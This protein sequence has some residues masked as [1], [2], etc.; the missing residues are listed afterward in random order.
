MH[1][2]YKALIED[3]GS[4]YYIILNNFYTAISDAID[5]AGIATTVA[6]HR[7]LTGASLHVRVLPNQ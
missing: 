2:H 6:S 1:A 3:N 5:H 4:Q 7:V